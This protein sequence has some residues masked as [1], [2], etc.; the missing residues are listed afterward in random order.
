MSENNLNELETPS[1]LT[2]LREERLNGKVYCVC[3]CECG[4]TKHILRSSISSGR[5]RS[6]GCLRREVTAANN[7]SNKRT[8][9]GLAVEHRQFYDSHRDMVRR[10]NDPK[11][12]AYEDYGGSG[13]TVCDRWLSLSNF[14]EDMLSSYIERSAEGKQTLER[15]NPLL[16]YS[17]D[18]C[19]WKT[20][21]EQ[22]VNRTM[23]STNKTGFTGVYIQS[24]NA[25]AHWTDYFTKKRYRKH[26]SINKYGYELAVEM[27]HAIRVRAIDDMIN[28]GAPYTEFHGKENA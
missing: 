20:K 9:G 21:D 6:C 1:R 14:A 16:G 25:V 24:G 2:V 8:A 5:T 4:N 15:I 7:R 3:L 19:C 22:A 13:I 26:F 11:S 27:A 18:N 28:R 17:P 10:C 23:W 12:V